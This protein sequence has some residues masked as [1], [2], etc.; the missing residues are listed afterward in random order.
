MAVV[1]PHHPPGFSLFS[2]K[3][4]WV[5][6]EVALFAHFPLA[7]PWAFSPHPGGRSG[8]KDTPLQ[9]L[10]NQVAWETFM[11]SLHTPRLLQGASCPLS[12][13]AV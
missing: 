3:W 11:S 4:G 6:H 9:D 12:S 7:V 5:H 1:T 2:P 8:P 10:I 13:L